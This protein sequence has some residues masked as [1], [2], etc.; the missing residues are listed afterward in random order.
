MRGIMHQHD[1]GVG[2]VVLPHAQVLEAA[3]LFLVGE[4]AG[5]DAVV[6]AHR[7]F[8]FD[9]QEERFAHEGVLERRRGRGG[10]EDVVEPGGGGCAVRGAVRVEGVEFQGGGDAEDDFEGV[11]PDGVGDDLFVVGDCRTGYW[12]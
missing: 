5:D 2:F 10:V 8:G 11:A 1:D 7:A 6:D 12:G 4:G 3:H 9:G